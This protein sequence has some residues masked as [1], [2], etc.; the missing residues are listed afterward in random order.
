MAL[1]HRP[2]GLPCLGSGDRF[3]NGRVGKNQHVRI[4]DRINGNRPELSGRCVGNCAAVVLADHIM[5]KG[6]IA[7]L[8]MLVSSKTHDIVA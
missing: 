5:I 6:R 8:R 3:T 4:S 2:I 1:P 7:R